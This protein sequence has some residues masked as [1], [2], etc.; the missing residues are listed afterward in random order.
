MKNFD[1]TSLSARD[2]QLFLAVLDCGSVTEAA[3]QLG[4]TQSAVSHGLE[5]LRTLT[6]DALFVKSGR[7]I[8]ATARARALGDGA[9]DLLRGLRAFAQAEQPFAPAHWDTTLTVAANDFQRELLLPALALRLRAQAPRLKLRIVNSGVPAAQWLRDD[10]VQLVI[11]PRPPEASDIMQTR[12][13][14]DRYV[15][16]YDPTQRQAPRDAQDFWQADHATVIYE[17]GRHLDVDA[18]WLAQ[19]LKRRVAIAVPGFAALPGFLRGSPLLAVVP[20][21]LAAR[22]FGDLA[23]APLPLRAPPL[24][25]YAVWHLRDQQ[26]PAHCWLRTQLA[27][28][29]ADALR[30]AA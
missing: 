25:M 23:A 12:L 6:S 3:L 18:Q 26:D 20:A 13:F 24:P 15:V 5:R 10:H 1:E 4:L 22:H 8:V 19:G 17:G 29:V 14:E 16:V 9:R 2:L 27:A 11:S 21:L 28:T 30:A 7:G